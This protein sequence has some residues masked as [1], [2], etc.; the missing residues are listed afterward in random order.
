VTLFSLLLGL[1]VTVGLR[2]WSEGQRDACSPYLDG[3]KSAQAAEYVLSGTRMIDVPCTDWFM[4]QPMRIQILSIADVGL[5]LVFLLNA[6]G[7]LREW[8]HMRRRRRGTP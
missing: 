5:A 8:L 2:L 7:D 1:M 6:L 4:R 3:N